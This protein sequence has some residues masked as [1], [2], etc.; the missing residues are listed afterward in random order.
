ML[1]A[2]VAATYLGGRVPIEHVVD[3]LEVATV[4]VDRT[5]TALR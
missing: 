3:E 4:D 1:A 5:T 2:I